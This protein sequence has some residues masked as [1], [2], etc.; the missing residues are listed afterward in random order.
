MPLSPKLFQQLVREPRL[1]GRSRKRPS[2]E[3]KAK[4]KIFAKV[5]TSNNSL[6]RTKGP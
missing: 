5:E 3:N 6:M 2:I 1:Q 4:L